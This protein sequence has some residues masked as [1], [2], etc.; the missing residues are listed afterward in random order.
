MEPIVSMWKFVC[1]VAVAIGL[2]TEKLTLKSPA[3][4][5]RVVNVVPVPVDGDAAVGSLSDHDRFD[6]A[7]VSALLCDLKVNVQ[8]GPPFGHVAVSTG[9]G[10]LR[11]SLSATLFS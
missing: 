7:L 5:K 10:A 4:V 2:D 6:H 8:S 1:A 3:F 11:K 9:S